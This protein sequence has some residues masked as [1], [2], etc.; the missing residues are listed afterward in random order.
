MLEISEGDTVG[1]L[2]QHAFHHLLS[3]GAEKLRVDFTSL[4]WNYVGRTYAPV[5]SNETYV[6]CLLR[7]KWKDKYVQ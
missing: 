7:L 4:F 3:V 2:I 5:L 6:E 1:W